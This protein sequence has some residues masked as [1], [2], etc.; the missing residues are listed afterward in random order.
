[1]SQSNWLARFL[2]CRRITEPDE[3]PLYAYKCSDRNYEELRVL[4]GEAIGPASKP[5][6]CQTPSFQKLFCLFAAETWRRHHAGGVWRWDTVFEAVGQTAPHTLTRVWDWVDSGLRYWGRPLL[7]GQHGDRKFL[8]TIICE[9]GLL[10]LSLLQQENSSLNQYLRELLAEHHQQRHSPHFELAALARQTALLRLPKSLH[11]DIVYRLSG[12]LI[13]SVVDLQAKVADAVDPIAALDT[14][15]QKWRNALP[16]SLEDEAVKALLGGLMRQAKTLALVAQQRLGWRRWLIAEGEDWTLESRLELPAFIT[17][18]SLRA[19]THRDQHPPRLRLLLRGA[20]GMEA[21]ARLT[22]TQGESE[23][24]R[25]RVE[26][27][28]QQGIRRTGLDAAR[29]PSLWL[30]DGDL[31][32]ELPIGGGFELGDLPWVFVERDSDQEW[33]AEGSARTKAPQAWVLAPAGC[34]FTELEGACDVKGGA[35]RW[36]RT[37]YRVRGRVRF[38]LPT[39]ESCLIQCA[40]ES[41]SQEEWL[42]SGNSLA[43][44]LNPAPVFLGMPKLKTLTPNGPGTPARSGPLEWRSL[45]APNAAWSRDLTACA[46][47]VWIR[48]FDPE[49]QSLRMR[50]QAEV[51]PCGASVEIL[52]IGDPAKP[53]VMHLAGLRGAMLA[54]LPQAGCRI[55]VESVDNAWQIHCSANSGLPITQFP[56]ELRWPTGQKLTLLLP[57]PCRGAAFARGGKVLGD[58]PV[59][60]GRLGAVQAVA[61][62]PG[63]G[64]G[65]WLE[66]TVKADGDS[67]LHRKLWLRETLKPS[68]NGRVQFELH[69]WEERLDS[70]LAMTRKL[71]ASAGVE[72]RDRTRVA[73]KLKVARF[74]VEFQPDRDNCRVALSKT[75][76]GRLEMDWQSRVTVK[77]IPLWNPGAEPTI[78]CRD[79][80]ESV[81]AWQVPETLPPGPWWLL[82]CDG[83]WARFRPMLWMVHGAAEV[84][85]DT[86]DGFTVSSLIQAVCSPD[87]TRPDRM[88]ELAEAL[89]Q[90]PA[91]PDWAGVFEYCK[92]AR[93]YPA[94]ALDLLPA[95]A[96]HPE[97]MALALLRS[98]E[99]QFDTVWSL[100]H[101]LPFSWHLLPARSWRTAA[102][103]HFA[104]LRDAL[105]GFDTDDAMR[106]GLFE[107][108]RKRAV[109]RQA[110]FSPLC[111]WMQ[112]AVFPNQPINRMSE[113]SLAKREPEKLNQIIGTYEQNLQR[114]GKGE[115]WTQGP[116]VLEM[117]ELPDFPKSRR[118]LNLHFAF[119][120]VRCAPFVAAHFN[121]SDKACPEDLLFEL[122]QLRDFDRDWFDQVF[123]I[124][125]CL[126][127]AQSA[128]TY[129]GNP[130]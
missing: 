73:A 98:S 8:L 69:R 92:L 21:V 109:G 58:G 30:S 25:Y 47:E 24:A 15:D 57:F 75:A 5:G 64:N 115:A 130:S 19:W 122:R 18:A 31:E 13:Q 123:A 39:G 59:A 70:L 42:L 68:G 107:G 32:T 72:I 52:Q 104:H 61:Q 88:R 95:L 33:L 125:L 1:M 100:A 110:L 114:D 91:H 43:L 78:L 6:Y 90:N 12:D 16:V 121:L 126:G 77:M 62:S 127:L 29:I 40:A 14:Q 4:I 97:A 49:T 111:D 17:G 117:A 23:A 116:I 7:R 27:L 74:D 94:S 51:L 81:V 113:L 108:F 124:A 79:E 71:D 105:V 45:S 50:R 60:L 89:A 99:E 119:R 84:A 44:A 54:V 20:T 11:Q 103:R 65:F 63:G 82:G 3:R 67:Q 2:I 112:E 36:E 46:G 129:P 87:E 35:T 55:D 41:D 53:G 102:R 83:D 10:P 9:G 106:F 56:L 66:A 22:R 76:V 37:L 101:Q 120:A 38:G 93:T 80:E 48:A 96:R 118:Y 85:T 26:V 28:R 34:S 86:P 128:F